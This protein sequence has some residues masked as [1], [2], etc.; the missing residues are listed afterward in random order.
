MV[1]T[2]GAARRLGG[3]TAPALTAAAFAVGIAI[4]AAAVFG[5]LGVVGVAVHGRAV[6]VLAVAV[7]LAAMVADA[8]GLRV[9]PQ[10]RFQVPEHWR[11]AMPLPRAVFLYGL[12]LGT[13]LT[14]YLPAAAAWALLPLSLALGSVTGALAVGFGFAAGRALPVLV[15]AARGGEAALAE[16]PQGLRI[17]RALAAATLLAALVAGEA[18]A[19]TTVASPAGEPSAAGADLAWQQP[20]VGGFLLRNGQA[21]ALLP[22]ND[23]SIGDSLV[24]W[25]VGP[26]VTVAA[27]DTLAPTQQETVPGVQKLAVSDRWLVYRAAQPDG[28]SQIRAQPLS[29]LSRSALVVSANRPGTLG[30]PYLSGDLVVYHYATSGA[31]WLTAVNIATGTRRRVRFSG[32]EQLL[33]PSLL[34]GRLLYVRASRCSQQLRL[35]PLGAGKERVLYELPPL[36]GQ[37]AGHERKHTSQGEHLP[38]PH[39]PKTTTRMLWTTALS[40]TTA[41]VTVL[42]PRR[43]GRTAPTLLAVPRR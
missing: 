6:V 5:A 42:T 36:A 11:R 13:G 4:G 37:D 12:L 23:P 40:A 38:C 7:S 19:G 33:N 31:S 25:H 9:R 20:G 27:R 28:A 15:L 18:R 35:G 24:A 29:D 1:G 2:V 17:L 16:R 41:Y 3:R 32:D 43:G 34:G 21:A 26:A 39:R 30:R 8:L 22:G 10:L 14:T